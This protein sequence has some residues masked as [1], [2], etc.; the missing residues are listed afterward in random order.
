MPVHYFK[1]CTHCQTLLPPSQQTSNVKNHPNRLAGS[2]T[3]RTKFKK[4]QM[5][6]KILKKKV[7]LN[8]KVSPHIWFPLNILTS[9]VAAS[10][11]VMEWKI[12]I[13]KRLTPNLL[14]SF[15]A[16]VHTFFVDQIKASPSC[17][18]PSEHL[19][20]LFMNIFMCLPRKAVCVLW[21]VSVSVWDV[22][23]GCGKSRPL[24]LPAPDRV[25]QGRSCPR[26]QSYRKQNKSSATPSSPVSAGKWQA[27]T[28]CPAAIYN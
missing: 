24:E 20:G 26:A 5:F 15:A 11:R 18:W 19:F 7:W 12:A 25:L 8:F 16:I 14:S 6:K 2:S 17:L 22:F 27:R 13:T 3:N 4:N 21:G 9:H 10:C 23:T 1:L 28:F